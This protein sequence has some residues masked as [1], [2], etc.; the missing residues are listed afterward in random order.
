MKIQMTS[1]NNFDADVQYNS[2]HGSVQHSLLL[3]QN[4]NRGEY[5]RLR[6]QFH[7]YTKN[8]CYLNK[9]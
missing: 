6:Q 3:E 4:N 8:K 2:F 5:S 1:M 9:S 7:Y